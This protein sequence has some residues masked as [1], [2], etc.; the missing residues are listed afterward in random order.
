MASDSAIRRAC[1]DTIGD[2][3]ARAAARFRGRTALRFADRS[4]RYDDLHRVTDQIAA[5]LCAQGLAKGDRLVAYGRNSD[6]YLLAW[7]ACCKAG[8]IHVPANYALSATELS[9][10]ITQSGA[11]FVLFDDNLAETVA[12]AAPP[13]HRPMMCRMMTSRKFSTH[14]APRAHQKARP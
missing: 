2:S 7:L 11:R 4:W 14:P 8:I 6:H 3:I 5:H 9:Y 13:A 1:R 12:A 10:I